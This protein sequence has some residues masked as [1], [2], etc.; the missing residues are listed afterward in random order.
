MSFEA[1][2]HPISEIFNKTEFSIPRNQRRYVWNKTHWQDFF[3]DITISLENDE[4]PHFI[5]SIVLKDNGKKNGIS[6]FT[7]IDGQQRLTTITIILLSIMKIFIERNKPNDFK[8]TVDYVRPKNNR[9]Q[10]V[11]ILHS[12]HHQSLTE[13]INATVDLKEND[14]TSISAF[15]DS[16]IISRRN[17]EKIGEAYKFFYSKIIN[18][19]ESSPSPDTLL[20]KIRDAIISML[21]VRVV[22]SSEEDSYTIF[23][24]LN[25]RGQELESHELIKNYIMRYIQPIETRDDAKRIWEEMESQLGSNL[26]RF[27]GHYILH[28]FGKTDNKD[29]DYQI[30]RNRTKGL[31]MSEYL[32]DVKLKS[33]YYM[34]FVDP[35]KD[36][37]FKNCSDYEYRIFKFFKSKRQEQFRPVILSLIHQKE[38]ENLDESYYKLTLEY[39]Y[40][41]FICYN[42]IGEE[43]S[44]KLQ[45]VVRKYAP[46]LEDKWSQNE[47][48]IFANNLKEKI[49]SIEWFENSFNTLGWSNHSGMFKGEKNKTRVQIT[50]EIIEKYISNRDE[51]GEYTIEHILPDSEGERNANIGNLIPLE[52]ELNRRCNNKS[53]EEKCA[54]YTESNFASARKFADLYRTE[55]FLPESRTKYLAKLVYDKILVLDQ[56]D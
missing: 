7:I 51:I 9:N 27:I 56:F 28:K 14:N 2:D 22:C 33:E 23:E 16:H 41:F 4:T 48:E 3:E 29:S 32:S 53:L 37:E 52:N 54:V 6:T 55:D 21:L 25:A 26:K 11:C 17:D 35:K 44:N 13:L 31:N 34:K 5:G 24:I 42:I 18:K 40:N 46:I 19:I 8:G 49:P 45:E 1:K 43:N 30:F 15:V 36:G 38:L 47:L 39:I 50:L 20:L 10:D 12:E